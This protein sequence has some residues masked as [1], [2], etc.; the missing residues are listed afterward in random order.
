MSAGVRGLI[1]LTLLIYLQLD[2]YKNCVQACSESWKGYLIH[3]KTC[4]V[5][6]WGQIW[7][8]NWEFSPVPPIH[9]L[10]AL[11]LTSC[12]WTC[13]CLID[14]QQCL[15]L[16]QQKSCRRS[17]Q[18]HSCAWTCGTVLWHMLGTPTLCAGG[19]TRS[20]SLQHRDF[21]VCVVAD[22]TFQ[23]GCLPRLYSPSTNLC[24]AGVWFVAHVVIGED[25][26][27]LGYSSSSQHFLLCSFCL[28][29]YYFLSP[30]AL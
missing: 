14:V 2:W 6:S 20:W 18:R 29:P 12:A 28:S 23:P 16:V 15:L 8:L 10:Y 24:R 30:A 13:Y 22:E 9:F 25:E 17:L 4:R 7:S 19:D 1:S 3:P 11:V 5:I 26:Y 27:S 21:Q